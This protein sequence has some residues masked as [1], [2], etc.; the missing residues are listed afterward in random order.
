MIQRL[1]INLLFALLWASTIGPFTPANVAVGFAVGFVVLLL[2]TPRGKPESYSRKSL[3]AVR[4]TVYFLWELV[5]ANMLVA[6]WTISPLKRLSPAVIYVPIEEDMSD[7]EIATL[8]NVITLTPGTLTLDVT[9]DR[10]ALR[11]H[12]M[13]APDHDAAR[14]EMQRGFMRRLLEVTR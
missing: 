10:R 1:L 4:F 8:A 13:H 7:A 6:W 11:V 14:R 5:R 12:C 3:A 2:T 9:E